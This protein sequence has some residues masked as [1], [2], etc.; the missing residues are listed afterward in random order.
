MFFIARRH[1]NSGGILKR[2]WQ[3]TNE[4]LLKFGKEFSFVIT[5]YN[6]LCQQTLERTI[7]MYRTCATEWLRWEYRW[8]LLQ[9]EIQNLKSD[10]FCFQEVEEKYYDSH[11]KTLMDNLG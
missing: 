8:N 6:V 11:F 1:P 10:I 5:S 4:P 3:R 2:N 7:D 9:K